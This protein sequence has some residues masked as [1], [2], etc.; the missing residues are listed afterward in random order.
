MAFK[1]QRGLALLAPV[2]ETAPFSEPFTYLCVFSCWAGNQAFRTASVTPGDPLRR[3]ALVPPACSSQSSD[4]TRLWK[5]QVG[6][7]KDFYNGHRVID[8]P[9]EQS[10][11]PPK[12]DQEAEGHPAA[13]GSHI[14]NLTLWDTGP[15]S[16]P[17]S[18]SAGSAPAPGESLPRAIRAA[19]SSPAKPSC[20]C[21]QHAFF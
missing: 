18:S 2:S 8:F 9:E 7:N 19:L 20:L 4:A 5:K 1:A 11:P 21:L 10:P 3:S 6:H 15:E 14:N 12:T 13:S 16:A 17:S